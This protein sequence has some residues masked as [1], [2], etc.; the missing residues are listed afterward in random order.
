[1]ILADLAGVI[2][3]VLVIAAFAA[4]NLWGVALWRRRD[5]LTAYS[6]LQLMMG[7]LVAVFAAVVLIARTRVPSLLLPYWIIAFPLLLMAMF[8][9]RQHAARGSNTA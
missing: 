8:W 4:G 2:V 9:L 7:G 5:R 6:G 3:L 1:M